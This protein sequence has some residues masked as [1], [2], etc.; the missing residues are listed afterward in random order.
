MWKRKTA[1]NENPFLKPALQRR[2]SGEGIWPLP[3]Y[4]LE[5]LSVGDLVDIT[6]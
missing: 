5:L 4:A 1:M 2:R 3:C 6:T